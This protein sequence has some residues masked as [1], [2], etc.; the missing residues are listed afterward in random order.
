MTKSFDYDEI[1]VV[2]ITK[3]YF[4]EIDSIALLTKEEEKNLFKKY[5]AGDGAAKQKIAQANLR[6]VV[7]IAKTY[8][9]KSKLNFLDLIQE[10]NLGLLI[11]IEKFDINKGYKFSTYATY[12]IKQSIN[13]A[14]IE[15][16]RTIRLPEYLIDNIS[17]INRAKAQLAE[18]GLPETDEAILKITGLPLKQ[19][20]ATKNVPPDSTSLDTPL[21]DEDQCTVGELIEDDNIEEFEK[22]VFQSEAKMV[23]NNMLDTLTERE[24]NIIEHRFGLNGKTAKT[25]IETG[26]AVSLS[27][28]RVRQLEEQAM[29]KLR[30]PARINKMKEIYFT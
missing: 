25:L 17:K 27:R 13:R 5:G 7:S 4:R 6:L 30:H 21:G 26:E 11:A 10:G 24:K 22:R 3:A 20:K 2:D 12:W 15:Q 8:I 1:S 9:G 16:A 28:E 23:L 19:Y 18:Q 14:M 29:R